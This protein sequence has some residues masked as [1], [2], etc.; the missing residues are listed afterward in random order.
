MQID[1]LNTRFAING[2]LH[3]VA[4]KG[5]L[6]NA[7]ISNAH[8]AASVSLYAGQVLSWHPRGTAQDVLFL[9]ERAYFQAGK[10]IKG[11]V[12]VC[13]PWFGPDPQDKGRPAHGFARIS[14]WEVLDTSVLDDGATRLL[15]GLALNEQTR[16]WWDGDIA[17]QLEITVG[18]TL[19]LALTTHNR[20]TTAIALSQALH[21]YFAVGDIARTTV[22][23]L[24]NCAYIDKVDGGRERHQSGALGIAAEVDRIYTGVDRD[25]EI[26]DSAFNRIIRIHAEGSASAVVWN[27]WRDI[28]TGMADLN[29][30]DY[31]RMLCVESANA[32]PDVVHLAA[33]AS[34]T[35]SVLYAVE[36]E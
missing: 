6:V 36:A 3:F 29:D 13:W 14:T 23:G 16:A 9:S 8:A 33:G 18:D 17:A 25:L 20:G 22:H 5:D 31:L 27:P 35:L 12:P 21:T 30:D 4:G 10:A 28:A 34:H 24:E 11:G 19:R 26:H 7:E 15:L 32:G 1:T 2:Q